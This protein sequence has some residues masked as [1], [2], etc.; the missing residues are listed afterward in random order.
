MKWSLDKNAQVNNV[1]LHD[2]VLV[3]TS[4]LNKES[5]ELVFR[6]TAGH[7]IKVSANKIHHI[8]FRYWGAIILSEIFVWPVSAVPENTWE[9][10]DSG[11]NA[12]FSESFLSSEP[13]LEAKR[14]MLAHPSASLVVFGVSY[15]GGL[16]VVCENLDIN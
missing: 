11:W 12:L 13:R 1:P 3:E 16:A 8:N 10:P 5:I 2:S 15:G 4:I 9:I 7:L 14:I 6:N